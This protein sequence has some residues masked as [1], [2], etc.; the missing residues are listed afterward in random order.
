VEVLGSVLS[1]RAVTTADMTAGEA[2]PQVNPMP[3]YLQA[4]LTS[5]RGVRFNRSSLG[6]VRAA[7]GGHNVGPVS[8]GSVVHAVG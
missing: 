7:V 2:Q 6:N 4:L 3:P 5:I 1:W 8:E